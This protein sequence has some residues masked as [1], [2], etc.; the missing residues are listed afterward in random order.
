[1]ASAARFL[2]ERTSFNA[3]R[4]ANSF[5][6]VSDLSRCDAELDRPIVWYVGARCTDPLLKFANVCRVATSVSEMHGAEDRE[7]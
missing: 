3:L 4:D 5:G 1:M 6:G 2:V 7:S